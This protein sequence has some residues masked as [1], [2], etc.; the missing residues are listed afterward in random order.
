MSDF[1][2]KVMAPL[3]NVIAGLLGTEPKNVRGQDNLAVEYYKQELLNKVMGRVRFNGMP[4]FWDEGF[5][6]STLLLDGYF[7]ILNTPSLGVIGLNCTTSGTNWC[8]RPNRALFANPQLSNI[9]ERVIVNNLEKEALKKISKDN[10][11]VL[12]RLTWNRRGI[13][14]KLDRY[15]Y[16]LA[17]CDASMAVNMMNSKSTLIYAA[18]SKKEAEEYK[19]VNDQINSGTPAVFV[20][21]SLLKGNNKNLFITNPAKANF[22]A[23]DIMVLKRSIVNEFLTEIGVNNANT[24]KRERLNSEEVNANNQEIQ[25]N[26]EQWLKQ[27]NKDLDISNELFGMNMRFELIEPEENEVKNDE[28]DDASGPDSKRN[29]NKKKPDKADKEG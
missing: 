12:I 24:D 7:A 19:A 6:M 28:G 20:S 27:V 26:V 11:C 1:E 2:M 22:I 10:S 17:Q 21:D 16:L 23:N 9:G 4:E 25:T 18:A 5:V 8:Y 15:A 29:E 3:R 13:V 14:E